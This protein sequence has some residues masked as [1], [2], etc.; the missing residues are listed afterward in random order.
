MYVAEVTVGSGLLLCLQVDSKPSQL[1]ASLAFSHR[2]G[3]RSSIRTMLDVHMLGIL[4]IQS[5]AQ[6]SYVLLT[7]D[8]AA[9][10]LTRIC[11]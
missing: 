6:V 10:A 3:S 5:L 11:S 8:M 7:V 2:P 4:S 1:L 9:G